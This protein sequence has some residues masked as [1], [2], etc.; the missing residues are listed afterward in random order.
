MQQNTDDDVKND[1][2][3]PVD[4]AVR[5]R[6]NQ[7]SLNGNDSNVPCSTENVILTHSA[8]ENFGTCCVYNDH[9]LLE[10]LYRVQLTIS[11]RIILFRQQTTVFFL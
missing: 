6:S 7:Y 10:I 3:L 4:K 5:V 8:C 9:Y 2:Q 11:V 1:A